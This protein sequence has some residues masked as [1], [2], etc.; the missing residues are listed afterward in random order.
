LHFT[1]NFK[2]PRTR[3]HFPS[4][5][6]S[7]D[8]RSEHPL[9]ER[10]SRCFVICDAAFQ[11]ISIPEN[12][13]EVIRQNPVKWIEAGEQSKTLQKAEELWAWLETNGADR[14]DEVIV[15]GGGTVLDLGAF[16]AS[17]FKRGTVFSLIPTT[18][19]AMV[20]ASIGGKNGI[21]FHGIKNTIGTFTEP[22][23]ILIDVNWLKTLPQSELLNGWMELSKHALV[24]SKELWTTLQDCEPS[25]SKN[26]WRFLVEQGSAIKRDIISNDFLEKGARKQL[27][28]G[29]TVA[30]AL[31]ATAAAA[32][33]KIDHGFAVG[34]GMIV[35]LQW[36]QHLC[37]NDGIKNDLTHAAKVL[38][39]WLNMDEK[40][41]RWGWC[42]Q[43]SPETLWPYMRKDKK[44]RAGQVLDIRL[45]E[46]GAAK[47]DCQ[48]TR[49]DFENTWSSA[50]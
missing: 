44:N 19:L 48:I 47:W 22:N 10:K 18:L 11:S 50:F 45:E 26:N 30:H 27:N 41:T 7:K 9:F 43:Q 39:N 35:A 4:A 33:V 46:I 13:S 23:S 5:N 3:Y 24:Q 37:Q 14:F 17:T 20:D 1:H 31:E 15:I 34:I 21:N 42:I 40:D 6:S 29:H 49:E 25:D 36:S 16:V 12:Y 28:F 2:M 38:R 8:A 32:Q